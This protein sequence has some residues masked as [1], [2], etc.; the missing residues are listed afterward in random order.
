MASSSTSAIEASAE[1]NQASKLPKKLDIVLPQIGLLTKTNL[2]FWLFDVRSV[3]AQYKCR[4][5]IDIN[6]PHPP[7]TD[8]N[9]EIWDELAISVK[10][11]LERSL[12]QDIKQELMSLP[13]MPETPDILIKDLKK[14]ITGTGHSLRYNTWRDAMFIERKDF[15]TIREFVVEAR[16]RIATTNRSKMKIT[17]YQAASILLKNLED[18]LESS[19]THKVMKMNEDPGIYDNYTE[20][21][22]LALCHEIIDHSRGKDMDNNYT[23][24][25]IT[26]S[27]RGD[28]ADEEDYEGWKQRSWPR[29]GR[30]FADHAKRLR[31]KPD[32]DG[33]CGYCHKEGHGAASCFYLNPEERPSKW[34][35]G[36]RG[37]WAYQFRKTDNNF[38]IGFIT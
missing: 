28:E 31:T 3:V 4:D 13:E 38:N 11:W 2:E 32:I 22:Y 23:A 26:T 18:E 17:L 25:A 15:A 20:S 29:I 27:S 7:K 33:K 9:Y 34:Q 35:P 30:S 19:V 8:P 10:G 6:I 14:I 1:R 5:L 24:A 37:L 36:I 16:T 21:Q 12:S